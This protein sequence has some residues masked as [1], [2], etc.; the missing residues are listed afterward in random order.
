MNLHIFLNVNIFKITNVL[1]IFL[2]CVIWNKKGQFILL[3][4]GRLFFT[5]LLI[6][7]QFLLRKKKFL[8]IFNMFD[9]L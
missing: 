1:F 5:C 6:I 4:I 2:I 3:F 9:F 7:C 8:D